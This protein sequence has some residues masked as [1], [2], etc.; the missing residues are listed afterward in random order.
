MALE[1]FMN[2]QLQEFANTLARAVAGFSVINN[3]VHALVR[4]EPDGV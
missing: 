3:R 1:L 2:T 4:L